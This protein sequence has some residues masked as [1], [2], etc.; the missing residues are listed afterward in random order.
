MFH[1]IS[2]MPEY[3]GKSFEELRWEDY[4]LGNRGTQTRP[5]LF[6]LIDTSSPPYLLPS[7]SPAAAVDRAPSPPPASLL[8]RSLQGFFDSAT[9]ADADA[10]P[11]LDLLPPPPIPV[12][13]ASHSAR[14]EAEADGGEEEERIIYR[15]PSKSLLDDKT[16]SAPSPLVLTSSAPPAPPAP[17][18]EV[19]AAQLAPGSRLRA[20]NAANRTRVTRL[21]EELYEL[22]E[23]LG[24]QVAAAGDDGDTTTPAPFSEAD[25][26]LH[27]IHAATR[28]YAFAPTPPAASLFTSGTPLSPPLFAL[29]PPPHS[30]YSPLASASA[31]AAAAMGASSPAPSPSP[32]FSALSPAPSAPV[33]TAFPPPASSPF[34]LRS[35]PVPMDLSYFKRYYIKGSYVPF[36]GTM[37]PRIPSLVTSVSGSSYVRSRACAQ[38]TLRTSSRT[39]R[40]T[41]KSTTSRSSTTPSWRPTSPPSSTPE[42]EVIL[43]FIYLFIM[44]C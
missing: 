10:Q 1:T 38:R 31:A 23:Q 44:R 14:D 40:A 11:P 28:D 2:A 26:L 33:Y 37:I 25:A 6:S 16:T 27:R 30:P 17:H 4:Q 5:S 20:R 19:D 32:G 43:L 13:S 21:Y 3:C 15:T 8:P 12:A 39:W 7:P 34:A 9:D 29:P 36:L 24:R 42:T 18:K 22:V 41:R 35:F